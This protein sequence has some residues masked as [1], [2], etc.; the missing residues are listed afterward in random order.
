MGCRWTLPRD[1]VKGREAGHREREDEGEEQ[2]AHLPQIGLC[3]VKGA[4]RGL[5]E[6]N[7][8]ASFSSGRSAVTQP[9]PL[10]VGGYFGSWVLWLRPT[11]LRPS[12][13]NPRFR[14]GCVEALALVAPSPAPSTPVRTVGSDYQGFG[15]R[16]MR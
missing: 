1:G 6:T 7:A 14:F 8:D 12:V 9:E 11:H 10:K 15:P 13:S 2:S 4:K 3:R 5:A 16:S